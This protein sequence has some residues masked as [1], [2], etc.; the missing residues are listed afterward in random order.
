VI[1]AGATP[2]AGATPVTLWARADITNAAIREL[3]RYRG[4]L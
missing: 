3:V 4:A 2:G 1:A